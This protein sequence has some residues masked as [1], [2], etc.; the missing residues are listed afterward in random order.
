MSTHRLPTIALACGLALLATA[1]PA[2]EQEAP[3]V[4]LLFGEPIV[5]ADLDP[6]GA[7]ASALD[8]EA[9]AR[10]R[11]EKLRVRVWHA[12]LEDYAGQREV[13]PT[14]AEIVSQIENTRRVTALLAAENE[15]RRAA[16]AVELA[17]AELEASRRATLQQ[18]LGALDQVLA[19]D[20]E[21]RAGLTDP[22]RSA[23]RDQVERRVARE[24]VRKWKLEKALFDDFGG[25]IAF[26]QAG[27]EPVDAYRALLQRY[28]ANGAFTLPDP[29]WRPAIYGYFDHD[30]VYLDE[31]KGRFYFQKPWWERTAQELRAAG[32]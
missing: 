20:A 9:L 2:A 3:V 17:T 5:A 13:D 21:R 31:A 24:W 14:E 23:A 6:P 8:A 16:I 22:E 18:E 27:W 19:Y 12:V 4:A 10:A 11:A 7:S 30:F 29:V 1:G 32:F 26:Q 15:K 25:R 28:E